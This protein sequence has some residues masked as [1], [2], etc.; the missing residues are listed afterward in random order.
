MHGGPCSEDELQ[1]K[2]SDP[3]HMNSTGMQ[4]VGGR[5]SI[6]RI[7]IHAIVRAGVSRARVRHVTTTAVIH[8]G[9]LRMV[10]N[11]ETLGTEL[12]CLRLREFEAFEHPHIE[13][14]TA[15]SG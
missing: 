12:E 5:F 9:P 1:A 11:V 4:K 15:R 7:P 3:R 14:E 13:I 8:A 6:V 10:K 2:L